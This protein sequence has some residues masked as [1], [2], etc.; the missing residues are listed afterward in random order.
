MNLSIFS[1]SPLLVLLIFHII[2]YSFINKL[3]YTS[4]CF[5]FIFLFFFSIAKVEGQVIETVLF[6]YNFPIRTIL[7][8]SHKC[9]Y[10]SSFS[11]ISK[12]FLIFFLF[13]CPTHQLLKSIFLIITYFDCTR[14]LSL[15]SKY[16]IQNLPQKANRRDGMKY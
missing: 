13:L 8:A 11:L 12:Y 15:I 3:L 4:V 9:Q 1:K 16:V 7:A 10:V 14:F 6:K 2:C 5:R